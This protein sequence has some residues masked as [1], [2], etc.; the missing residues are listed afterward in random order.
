MCA[1]EDL[2]KALCH[3]HIPPVVDGQPPHFLLETLEPGVFYYIL[4]FAF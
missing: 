3:M 4:L 2:K 1:Q